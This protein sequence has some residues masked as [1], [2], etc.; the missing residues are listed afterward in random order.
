MYIKLFENFQREQSLERGDI[1]DLLEGTG[2]NYTKIY[3]F[4]IRYEKEF[5]LGWIVLCDNPEDWVYNT[6]KNY[7]V[8]IYENRLEFQ[9]LKKSDNNTLLSKIT[10]HWLELKN[11][12]EMYIDNSR[13]V[14]NEY[15]I[16]D[17]KIFYLYKQLKDV[18]I[19]VSFSELFLFLYQQYKLN[20]VQVKYLIWI[21][22]EEKLNQTFLD[23]DYS[24]IF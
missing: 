11:W 20:Y 2:I 13:E 18:N 14:D 12:L 24:L 23:L 10:I 16:G 22:F 17:K 8:N 5:Y 6:P 21:V 9:W 4:P 19:K 7:Q 15:F 1:E 3:E